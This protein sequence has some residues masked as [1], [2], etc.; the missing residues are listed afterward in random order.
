MQRAAGVSSFGDITQLLNTAPRD[1]VELLRIA[2]VVRNVTAS[3]GCSLADR[4]R[5]NSTYAVKGLMG[6]EREDTGEDSEL[7][8]KFNQLSYRL[9]IYGRLLVLRGYVWT[10]AIVTRTLLGVLHVFGQDVVLT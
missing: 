5:V 2:A 9:S 7:D 3:L 6:F 8:R 4:L 1:V 10:H